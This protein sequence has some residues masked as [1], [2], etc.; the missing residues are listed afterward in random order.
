MLTFVIPKT[1][2]KSLSSHPWK[3][4]DDKQTTIYAQTTTQPLPQTLSRHLPARQ[5]TFRL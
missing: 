5:K 3:G 1:A 2:D 4:G